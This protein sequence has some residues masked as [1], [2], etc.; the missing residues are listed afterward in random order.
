VA[1]G[2]RGIKD[3]YLPGDDSYGIG[4][5]ILHYVV[6][7]GWDKG[8]QGNQ[9][10]WHVIDNGVH[11]KWTHEYFSRAFWWKPENF[12][13]EGILYPQDVHPGNIVY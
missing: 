2:I 10:L 12:V 13:I 6:I 5:A 9:T 3:Y 4:N 8:T 7:D 11:K 1:W